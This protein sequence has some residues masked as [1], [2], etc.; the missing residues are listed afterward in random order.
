M[1]S[2]RRSGVGVSIGTNG[3]SVYEHTSGDMPAPLVYQGAV[4]GWNHIALV[5]E[6]KRPKLYV[7]GQLVRTGAISSR[8]AIRINPYW[9]GG[10]EYGFFDGQMDDVKIYNRPLSA[11]EI[12]AMAAA[13]GADPTG[14][15]F[16]E[17]R[18]DPANETGSGGDDPLSRNANFSV[19]LL[20]LKGRAGLD[21]GLSLSYNSLVWTRDAAT[22]SRSKVTRTEALNIS[23]VR[24]CC[25]DNCSPTSTC[26]GRR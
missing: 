20:G 12:G 22:G 3:V 19:P 25:A 23:C 6:G 1:E 24:A 17:A 13:G 11:G 9:I 10:M 21:L 16:S 18:K 2:A 8:S 26:W 14:N 4:T 5:Y 7:N 15:N